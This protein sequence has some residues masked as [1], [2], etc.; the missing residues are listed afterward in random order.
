MPE[1]F[2]VPAGNLSFCVETRGNP[3]GEPVIFVMGLGAQM[4]LWPEALLDHYADEGFRVIRFDNRDIGLS[5]HLKD[6]LEGHPV[7]VMARHRMGLPIPAPYTLHDMASDVCQ[8]MD[9]L[10][11]ASAHLVGVSMGGMISQ[12]VAANHPERVRSATLIMTSTNSPRLPM[13]K[14]QLIWRLAGIGSKGHD[15]ATVVARSLDFWKAIQSPGF[16]PR[17]QEVRE[18]I[19]RDYRRSYHPAGILRQTRAILATGSLSSAT[20]RIRVPVSV[21]HGKDDPLVRPVA[22]EQLGYL[23]PHARIEMIKG[24]GHDLPQ[25][26]LVQFAAI[27][28]ETMAQSSANG[29]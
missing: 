1:S 3:A 13:P 27:G 11:L 18:R 19:V 22:A 21:I 4:T 2:H 7:A 15:E 16:P 9:A 23:M 12:L 20:R 8:V 24:M 10:G 25:P 17:E 26:L 5:S 29:S 28:F 6:R 14:S